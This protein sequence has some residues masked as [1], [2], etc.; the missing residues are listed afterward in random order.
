MKYIQIQTIEKCNLKCKFC[1]NSYVEQSGKLMTVKLFNKI[2][3]D[4]KGY[5]GSIALHLMNEPT[6]D[7]RLFEFIDIVHKE[8]PNNRLYV[9]TNGTILDESHL[10]EMMNR[11]VTQI[12]V[13]CYTKPI[14]EKY[15][16]V[17]GITAHNFTD[18]KK[19]QFYN[20]GGNI[21]YGVGECSG[22][23]EKP[24]ETMFIKWNGKAVLCCS[25]YKNEA[26]M[27]DVNKNTPQE[28]FNN[29][30]YQVYREHLAEG[31]RDLT[32]CN[33]CNYAN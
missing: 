4:L 3:K 26:V 29:K 15:K 33:K 31:K 21:D 9:S 24:F 1:P 30:K 17:K 18:V 25:D 12:S 8:F 22:Y 27:G 19:E 10:K 11:G 7:K 16:N 14:F 5:K 28:I 23:C 32:L 13:S 2:I 6:L 20:R